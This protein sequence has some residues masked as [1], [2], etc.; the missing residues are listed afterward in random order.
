M[1]FDFDAVLFDVDGTLVDSLEVIVQG[2]GDTYEKFASIRPPRAEI[3]G[4]IGTPLHRQVLLYQAVEPSPT[5]ITE[6]IEFA[7]G[8]FDAYEDMEKLFEPAVEM[9]RL[10]NQK[11]IK[12][13]LVTSKSAV[14]LGSFMER[15]PGSLFVNEAVCASDVKHPKPHP[16]SALLACRKLGVD[17][18]RSAMIGDSV[19]DLQCARQAGLTSVAVTYGAGRREALLQE[20]P[21]V[22]FDTPEALLQWAEN[23]FLESPCPERS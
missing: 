8:R 13:A 20:S 9:L 5:K 7:I 3:L 15:F 16:E 4:N 6:M 1:S 23:A 18:S 22:V 10:C 21:D 2:L 14:E 19:F 17:P 12:T 11:Q